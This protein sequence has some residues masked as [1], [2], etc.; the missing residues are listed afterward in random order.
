METPPRSRFRRYQRTNN[1]SGAQLAGKDEGRRISTPIFLQK[2]SPEPE[3]ARII[4]SVRLRP[5]KSTA[6]D[7]V[8]RSANGEGG[9][10]TRLLRY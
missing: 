7:S 2:Y 8:I 5:H 10:G 4:V 1:P 3:R 9:N 6:L